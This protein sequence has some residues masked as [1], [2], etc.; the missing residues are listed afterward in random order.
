M[1]IADDLHAFRNFDVAQATA[2]LW[3]FKKRPVAR[4][5][6][7]FTATAALMSEELR[8]QLK[9]L[10]NGY[11]GSHTIA[12]EYNL[13]A[14]PSEGG[15]LS[16]QREET[17][18]PNL[19]ELIDQPLEEC[20]VRNVKQLNNA[21]G[22]VLRLR[23]GDR[24]LYCVKKTN[25][26]WATRKKKGVM[27]IFFTEAGLD[28][29]DDPSFSI[30]RQFDFFVTGDHILMTSKLAFES[31]LNHRDSY[32]EAFMQLKREPGF[33]AAFADLAQLDDYV[34]NNATQLRRMNVIK[35]RGY[36]RNPEYLARLRDINSLRGWGIQFDDTGRIVPTG[37]T[38]SALMHVLLD[39]RLRSELSDN[40]YD[41]PS[42]S[43][44]A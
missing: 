19:Q 32:E 31:L 38:M 24:V 9:E 36:Y 8:D 20:L 37:E 1:T 12:E 4:Q 17:L 22:Y 40:Q 27:N 23:Q 15:F 35:A 26:D 3:V 25:S 41:V 21:A 16:V 43:L 28:I 33:S 34:G 2:S 11:R 42:T 14:Q 13:L 39:H 44:I 18:F 6:N 7:P 5:M 10:V 29:M 30:A